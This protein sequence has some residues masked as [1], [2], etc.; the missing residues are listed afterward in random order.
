VHSII[1]QRYLSPI[2]PMDVDFDALGITYCKAPLP[3]ATEKEITAKLKEFSSSVIEN[4][5][6]GRK[7][8]LVLDCQKK[9]LQPGYIWS[10]PVVTTWERFVI[11]IQCAP[12]KEAASAAEV[13]SLRKS[14]LDQIQKV[15]QSTQDAM[16][17]DTVPPLA[18]H[19]C[20][21][22]ITLDFQNTSLLDS[23]FKELKA[24]PVT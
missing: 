9:S 11:T 21:F 3:S 16:E 5:S 4:K 23:I 19:P 22:Q 6:K 7:R 1:F 18:G 12:H 13:E 8:S 15:V 20:S 24:N 14:V 17:K 2:E 10:T